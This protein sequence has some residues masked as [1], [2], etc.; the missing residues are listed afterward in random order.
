MQ[1]PLKRLIKIDLKII[2]CSSV[3]E[4][5]RKWEL[6]HEPRKGGGELKAT[7]PLTF[8]YPP[9]G[10]VRNWFFSWIKFHFPSTLKSFKYLRGNLAK[11][12]LQPLIQDF[13]PCSSMLREVFNNL[14]RCAIMKEQHFSFP[15]NVTEIAETKLES[16]TIV[17]F[18]PNY[19]M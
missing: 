10:L 2:I 16:R 1:F 11:K 4:R 6:L 9:A 18:Y 12:F 5:P 17:F 8:S 3:K 15:F 7:L 19:V 13:W 14:L